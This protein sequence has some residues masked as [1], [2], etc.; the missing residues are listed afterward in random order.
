MPGSFV[1]YDFVIILEKIISNPEFV[2]VE[3]LMYDTI[4][5]TNLMQGEKALINMERDN[6]IFRS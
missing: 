1:R 2:I 6:V 5:G 4:I 3:S